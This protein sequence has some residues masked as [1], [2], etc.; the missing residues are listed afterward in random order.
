MARR[1]T[2][3]R[4]H[5]QMYRQSAAG[6]MSRHTYNSQPEVK[7]RKAAK[8]AQKM[9]M[10]PKPINIGAMVGSLAKPYKPVK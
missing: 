2:N 8:R 4:A 1:S 10:A 7:A 5:A 3:A 9:G 6:K